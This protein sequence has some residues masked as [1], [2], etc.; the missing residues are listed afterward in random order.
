MS[1]ERHYSSVGACDHEDSNITANPVCQQGKEEIAGT[2]QYETSKRVAD[3]F[4]GVI[5]VDGVA[6][7]D[8]Q[9]KYIRRDGQKLRDVSRE[10]QVCDDS[11]REV[12]EAVETVDHEEVGCCVQPEHRVKQRLFRNLEIEGLVLLVWCEGSHARDSKSSLFFGQELSIT[13]IVR[14]PNPDDDAEENGRNPC[15]DEQPLPSG[16]VRFAVKEGDAGSDES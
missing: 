8:D 15:K 10:S 12:R 16:Q 13:G 1:K 5:G 9:S 2:D 3:T 14:H 6:D 4:F 7:D 11:G